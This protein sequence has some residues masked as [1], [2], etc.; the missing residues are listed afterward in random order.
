MP[1]ISLM[2]TEASTEAQRKRL[3]GKLRRTPGVSGASRLIEGTDDALIS[4]MAKVEIL[5]EAL[6]ALLVRLRR[7]PLVESASEPAARYSA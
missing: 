1:L 7:N 3:L 4:R 5:E 2:F 6:A